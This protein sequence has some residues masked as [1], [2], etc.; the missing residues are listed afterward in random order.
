MRH[1]HESPRFRA[2]LGSGAPARAKASGEPAGFASQVGSAPPAASVL[3]YE[4]L[5]VLAVRVDIHARKEP[6]VVVDASRLPSG[7][8]ET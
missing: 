7:L 2:G 4:K 1:K 8:I 6:A 3:L 5:Q